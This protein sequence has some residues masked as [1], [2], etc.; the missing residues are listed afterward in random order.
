MPHKKKPWIKWVVG[1]AAL[2][3]A[4]YIMTYDYGTEAMGVTDI[5][6]CNRIT[7]DFVTLEG[8]Y[9]FGPEKR[10]QLIAGDA[11]NWAALQRFAA[12]SPGASVDPVIE[13]ELECNDTRCAPAG[14]PKSLISTAPPQAIQHILE[15]V[16]TWRFSPYRKGRIRYCFDVTRHRLKVDTLGLEPT[17]VQD[18][19][20]IPV[21]KIWNV[22]SLKDKYVRLRRL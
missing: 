14:R 16:Y 1:L 7:T 17:E 12:L 22:Q 8:V 15:K 2:A 9:I 11:V 19:D 13:V 20:Q 5:Q 18:A 21:E 4:V 3:L 10:F 6:G